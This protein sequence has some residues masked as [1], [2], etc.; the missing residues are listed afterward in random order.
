M[1]HLR[2]LIMLGVTLLAP[3][4]ARA[5]DKAAPGVTMFDLLRE[6]VVLRQSIRAAE[7]D[8]AAVGTSSAPLMRKLLL[9]KLNKQLLAKDDEI[10][11][12]YRQGKHLE[13]GDIKGD[14][15]DVV[16]NKTREMEAELRNIMKELEA[17]RAAVAKVVEGLGE[18]VKELA[19]AGELL[20]GEETVKE[21]VPVVPSTCDKFAEIVRAGDPKK[22]IPTG[23]LW[24]GKDQPGMNLDDLAKLAAPILWFSPREPLIV[25]KQGGVEIPSKLSPKDD[26]AGNVPV[27]YY[28]VSKVERDP[29]N[30]R[31]DKE[32]EKEFVHDKKVVFGHVRG[33]TLRYYFY[34]P[35][36]VGFNR[37]PHDL[38]FIKL[39]IR[40]SQ[41]DDSGAPVP[42]GAA[43]EG[44][45]KHTLIHIQDV[46]GAAHGV[47]WYYNRLDLT[48]TEDVSLPITILVEE[49]KHASSPDRD[50]DGYYSP[51]YDVNRRLNDAWGVRDMVG[52]GELG[53]SRYQGHMTKRRDTDHRMMV[54]V[55][56][57]EA[58]YLE[59]GALL[60]LYKG[61]DK[62][63]LETQ[64]LGY[65]LKRIDPDNH[66]EKTLYPDTAAKKE[67]CERLK[68]L[69]KRGE[70]EPEICKEVKGRK[71][72]LDL[73]DRE[74]F[75]KAEPTV[76]E[77]YS[78]IQKAA[79]KSFGANR[80]SEIPDAMSFSYRF[81][82]GSGISLLPPLGRYRV[83]AIGGYAV[84]KMNLIFGEGRRVSL[85]AMY[86]P[87]AARLVDWYVSVGGEW[88]R[89][90]ES[91]DYQQRFVSEGGVKFRF[92]PPR[93]RLIPGVP[94]VKLPFLGG[95]LG[96]R[97]NGRDFNDPRI[98]VEMG[99][100]AF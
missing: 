13:K 61:P 90:E 72:I 41:V 19:S 94:R 33:L 79:I 45:P 74:E 84:P 10:L 3:L 91:H 60:R 65:E 43:G 64:G 9:Y 82:S 37:H 59:K 18:A 11:A 40:F 35:E 67:E 55:A 5:Q 39:Y 80:G 50:G 96:L 56:P 69:K 31:R 28:R 4:V 22:L 16:T 49:G 76:S 77:E 99:T 86:T 52:S 15:E 89:Q 68:D 81:D 93:I 63:K 44:R 21:S 62:R 34:Y 57:G 83:P 73:V 48:R 29:S 75:D 85:E 38:E 27:V 53:G 95:R 54:K 14:L 1:T 66:G 7:D 58:P 8:G 92:K 36:D 51:G 46:Y 23:L 24:C 20:K 87:S 70:A 12:H 71:H 47:T 42:D 98:V 17:E 25:G 88:V 97:A 78:L 32:I 100:G 26:T 6:R 30:P 2:I